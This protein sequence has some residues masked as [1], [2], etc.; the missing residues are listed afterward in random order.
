M[1][2]YKDDMV[3]YFNIGL[4]N[5]A[6]RYTRAHF[7]I[8]DLLKDQGGL[9][10]VAALIAFVLMKPFI[11]KRHDLQVFLDHVEKKNDESK[12]NEFNYNQQYLSKSLRRKCPTEWYLFLYNIR[13][14]M[15]CCLKK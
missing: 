11:F 3:A 13:K 8:I 4:D 5:Q 2:G 15:F 12:E 7:T 6:T 14:N 1:N 10:K 9:Q